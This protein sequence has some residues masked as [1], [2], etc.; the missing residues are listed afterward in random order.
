V[1][2]AP[3]STRDLALVA[4]FAALIAALGLVPALQILPF[5]A[6]VTA[7]TLGVMLAGSVLGA[8]RG[9]LAV[10]TFLVLVAAGLPLLPPSTVRPQGGPAVFT[11]LTA[12]FLVGWLLGAFVIGWLVERRGR[13]AV[14]AT[15]AVAN[16]VGGMLVIYLVGLPVMAWVGNLSLE[17][18]LT[19][20]VAFLP[21]DALKVAGSTVITLAVLRGYPGIVPTLPTDVVEAPR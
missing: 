2:R 10:L 17:Q 16:V 15:I 18:T 14:T 21:G 9:A 7:Q 6:P 1:D 8:R 12:G 20:L 19:A 3:S 11:S 4:V 13:R 5:G